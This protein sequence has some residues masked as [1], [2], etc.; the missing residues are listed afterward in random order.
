[1]LN[2]LKYK[3]AEFMRGRYGI[4]AFGRRLQ[5]YFIAGLILTIVLRALNLPG[6]GFTSFITL[7]IVIF[8]NMR[9]YSKDISKM[10]RQQE[11]YFEFERKM[12]AP[13]K[14]LKRSLFGT[15]ESIY[16]SCPNCKEEL[17]LPRGKGKIKVTCPKCKHVFIKR[18]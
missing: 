1:M 13:F 9:V 15:K 6:S 16:V 11:A 5:I 10:R 14:R 3:F 2:N 8:T 18:T 17:R 7:L 4:D 12:T